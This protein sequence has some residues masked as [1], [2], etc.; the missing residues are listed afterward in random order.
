M[1][2]ALAPLRL[3]Y[4][5]DSSISRPTED[6]P[7][8][9]RWE[10]WSRT[11]AS[12]L[13][14]QVDETLQERIQ[15]LAYLPEYADSMFHGIILMVQGVTSRNCSQRKEANPTTNFMMCL[16]TSSFAGVAVPSKYR[17]YFF[18]VIPIDPGE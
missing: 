10:Y 4:V 18:E 8:F 14:V 1:R 17:E 13:Y 7:K 2:F 15:N 16:K 6:N 9:D 3:E 12:W 11:V 5:I